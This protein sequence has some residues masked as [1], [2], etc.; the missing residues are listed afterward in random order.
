MDRDDSSVTWRVC[1]RPL[2]WVFAISTILVVAVIAWQALTTPRGLGLLETFPKFLDG[3]PED[4]QRIAQIILD[5]YR[6]YRANARY[7]SFGYY[8]CLFLSAACA[9]LAGLVIK[10]Q[11]FLKNEDLKKDVAAV[12]AMVSALLIT[13]STVGDFQQKWRANRAAAAK[14]ET[15]AYAFMTADRKSGLE[16]FSLQIQ[17]ISFERNQEIFS[18]DAKPGQPAVEGRQRSRNTP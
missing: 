16:D 1:R 17:A 11:Y 13:L 6:E 3:L 14:M 7:W 10:L 18:S 4:E 8:G 5:N 15:V 2:L 9:A 12:L